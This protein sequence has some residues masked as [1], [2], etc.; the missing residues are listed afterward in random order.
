MT[1]GAG[2]SE[3]VINIDGTF[4]ASYKYRLGLETA[5]FINSRFGGEIKNI[6]LVNTEGIHLL[7][8]SVG[9]SRIPNTPEPSDS[10]PL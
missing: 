10:T 3:F 2:E 1:I 5:K 7:K 9:F 8:N 6:V 4:F